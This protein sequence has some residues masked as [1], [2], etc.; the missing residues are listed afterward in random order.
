MLPKETQLNLPNKLRHRNSIFGQLYNLILITTR[1]RVELETTRE[2][3][4]R[5]EE[6]VDHLQNQRHQH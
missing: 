4:E 3:V 6:L 1:D 5:Q 2:V